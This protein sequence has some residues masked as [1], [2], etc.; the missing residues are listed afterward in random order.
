MSIFRLLP[1]L[2]VLLAMSVGFAHAQQQ[3][4]GP[5]SSALGA[6]QQE[7]RQRIVETLMAEANEMIP[8][9][10]DSSPE[11]KTAALGYVNAFVDGDGEK[12]IS[13]I[14]AQK[15]TD[16]LYPPTELIVAAMQFAV[17]NGAVGRQTLEKAALENPEYPG[18]FI[19]FARLAINENRQSDS[20][21]LLE[22]AKR[23]VDSG[24][25]SEVEN[26]HFQERYLDS[27]AD[28]MMRYEKWNEANAILN[29]LEQIS[30]GKPKTLVRQAEIAYRQQ[31][32]DRSLR[33]LSQFSSKMADE[34]TE[35]RRPELMLATWFNRDGKTDEAQK[36]VELANENYPDDVDVMAEYADWMVGRERYADARIAIERIVKAKGETVATKFIKGKIAFAQGGYGLAEAHFSELSLREPGNFEL[37]NLWAL[38]LIESRDQEKRQKAL[39]VAQRNV[40]V[41][42]NNGV[43]LGILGWVFYKLGDPNQAQNWLNRAAQTRVNS[44]EISYFVATILS[45]Q[46]QTAQAKQI[47]DAAVKHQGVFLY[48]EPAVELQKSLAKKEEANELPT[49]DK[50]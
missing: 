33:L 5:A 36:W 27:L 40:Q 7:S 42:P 45:E 37:A 11:R 50:K 35:S 10:V 30:S 47:I 6:N 46:G 31:D 18:I 8:G 48:R 9:D 23:L 24:S 25:W 16:P 49:P 20:L 32:A 34:G 3:P 29:Q 1:T 12:V 44:P 28:V 17:N 43:A 13:L 26:Q 22:K 39:Q 41:Q 2:V 4:N 14:K 21:A 19:A 38:S 15:Q